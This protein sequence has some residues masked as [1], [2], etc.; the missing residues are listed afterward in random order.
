MTD[1]TGETKEPLRVTFDRRLKLEFHGARITSDGGLLAY[2]E[3]DDALGLT[4]TAASALAEDRR[5]KNIRH[6]L[7]GLLRQAVYGRRA[8]YEDVNDAQRLARDPAMRAIVG[9]EG[10]DRPAA[11]SSEMGRFETGWLATEANLAAL[12]AL[13]GTWIDRVHA[14]RPPDGIILDIDSSESPTYGE[15]EDSAWNGH[16]RCTCYHPLFV[17]NQFGDLERCLLRPGNVH[18]ADAWRSVLEPVIARY[19]ERGLDLYFRGDAAFAKPELYELLEAEGISYAIRLP[20]NRVL[21]ARIA[22]L[23]TRPVGRPPKK[24]QVFFASFSYQAESWSKPRRV[25]AKVEWHQGE[26]YPRV[27]FIVTNLTR[28]AGRV[29]KF[30]NGRGTAEQWIKEGKQALRWTRLSCRVFRDNAVRLQLFALAYNLA[31]FL[32]SLALPNEV[33]HWSLT[34]LREKLVKIAARTVHHGRYTIFQLAEVAVPRALFA[35]IL[36]RIE[37][38]RPRSPP[39]PA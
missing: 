18:S 5:G 30:Y 25:V 15:Q 23:L 1:A 13:S 22:H 4:A 24:P 6:R 9:R 28:P 39:L 3:L 17:F 11:S 21:Q 20:A 7:L 36:R 37:R 31:N 19:R 16:F 10:L 33:A 14:R 2:R 35:V 38:L 26:L 12:T 29:V 32:R 8:G 27:G 34:T